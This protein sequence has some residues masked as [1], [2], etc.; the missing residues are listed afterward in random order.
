[1]PPKREIILTPLNETYKGRLKCP[2]EFLNGA[3]NV[4]GR[5]VIAR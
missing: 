2:Q 3:G 4:F 1:M 5:A